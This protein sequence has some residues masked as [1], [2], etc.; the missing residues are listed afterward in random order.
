[1]LHERELKP[2][3]RAL[4]AILLAFG[5]LGVMEAQEAPIPQLTPGSA[6]KPAPA[7]SLPST[8][9]PSQSVALSVPKAHRC[10]WP[11]TKKSA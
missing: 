10:K 2:I 1:M 11:W 7:L 3:R 8:S 5:Y 6:R 4:C 9:T